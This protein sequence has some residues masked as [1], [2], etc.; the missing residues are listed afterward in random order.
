MKRYPDIDNIVAAYIQASKTILPRLY[1]FELE[2]NGDYI[3]PTCNRKFGMY[4]TRDVA[5]KDYRRISPQGMRHYKRGTCISRSRLVNGG[6]LRNDITEKRKLSQFFTQKPLLSN[7]V[8]YLL[9][10]DK[11]KPIQLLV[12]NHV[13]LKPIVTYYKPKFNKKRVPMNTISSDENCRAISIKHFGIQVSGH[14]IF[15]REL[16]TTE[17]INQDMVMDYVESR[18][19]LMA[20][21]RLQ[22]DMAFMP[23]IMN[24]ETKRLDRSMNELTP[25]MK[26]YREVAGITEEHLPLSKRRI[27]LLSD[28]RGI[29]SE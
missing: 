20:K 26:H 1:P 8:K 25:G 4:T 19:S 22:S 15:D 9:G 7:A 21:I 16:L 23:D 3:C 27:G 29:R 11:Y 14:L 17:P 12:R 5:K 10:I 18:L 24:S 28:N 6:Y 2:Q 13:N